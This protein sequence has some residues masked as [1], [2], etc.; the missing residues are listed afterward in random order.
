MKR[1]YRRLTRSIAL[2][3][4]LASSTSLA[5]KQP[6]ADEVQRARTFFDAGAA[7]YSAAKYYDA[8]RSF[9]QAYELAP[10]PQVLFSLAQAERKEY[11][12]SNNAAY[13]RRAIQ[14]YKEYLDQVP[15]GG[16][17]SEATE[18][19]AD[20]EGRLSRL[21]PAQAQGGTVMHAEKRKARITVYSATPGAQVVV[22]NGAPQELP[23]FADLEPGK[24][25]V[26][27]FAEG[28]FDA[29]QDVSGDKPID[30]PIN[31]T[32][33]DRPALVTVAYDGAA[34][35]YV[36]GRIVAT[37]PI[38]RAVEVPPGIH[39]LSLSANGKKAYS[40]EVVLER[41]KPFKIEPRPEMSGQRAVAWTM[42]IGGGVGLLG[43]AAFGLAALGRENRVQ[44]L[45]EARTQHNITGAELDE[46]N[47]AIERRDT[48][49]T[50]AVV[51]TSIGAA[52][53]AGGLLLY[54]FDKPN[55]AV[56]PPRSVEPGPTP[57]KPGELEITAQ[58][59]LGPGIYGGG[60]TIRF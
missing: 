21:D 60:A 8:V 36:D 59:M 29:Q 24:H 15:T 31:L 37:T 27:V 6:T 5:A 22:D 30:V 53:A 25:V 32:L 14:H 46:H 52:L 17:R 13:L 16:R 43:G 54:L 47:R 48:F 23:Y 3:L 42:L 39:V 45:D 55:V 58:P 2:A 41:G 50:T 49:R 10:R 26:R 35:F 11:F 18:A 40:Q 57:K 7:A 9:E 34:D 12:A 1:S 44:E 19:K 4:V 38:G 20:L 56:L 28:Y 51:S 33:R